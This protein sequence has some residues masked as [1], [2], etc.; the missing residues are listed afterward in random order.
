MPSVA[1]DECERRVFGGGE[2]N[3]DLDVGKQS[4]VRFGSGPV[5]IFLPAR[6][7]HAR[8][9]WGGSG[10]DVSSGVSIDKAKGSRDDHSGEELHAESIESDDGWEGEVLQET[11]CL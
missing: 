11:D 4:P 10:F 2:E 5:H 7:V 3:A 9:P 8:N 1:L 6:D